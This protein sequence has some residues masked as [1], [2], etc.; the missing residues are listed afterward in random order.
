MILKHLIKP[1]LVSTMTCFVALATAA[2]KPTESPLANWPDVQYDNSIPDIQDVLGYSVGQRITSHDDMLRF[3]NS[4]QKAAPKHIKIFEY[5]ET[6][7]G[8]KLIFAAIGSEQNIANLA[9]F[10]DGMQALSD[11]RVTNKDKAQNLMNDLPASV[12]LEYSVHG[13]EISSTDAAMMTAYHLL[14]GKDDATVKNVMQ[15]S[16]V[17]IDPLQNPDGRSRF[18]ANYYSTVGM[19]HSGDRLT[20]EHNEPWPRGRANHYLFDMN[21]DWLAITQP[22]TKGRIASMNHYRPL[23]VIDLH[24]M[25]GDESY[26]F[27]PSAQ[28]I[29][30]HM[31]QAQI[32]NIN[33]VGRNNA[34]HFDANGFDY[35]T[36]DIFDAFYPGYGDSWPTFYGAAAS[37]YEVA[38]SRG[39]IFRRLDGKN[40]R[41]EDTVL[42]HFVASMSTAETVANNRT[43]LL[44]D[45]YQYQ[46]DAID[47]GKSDKKERVFILP[48]KRDRA[49][50]F[51]LAKLMTEHGVNVYQTTDKV[52]L[53][54]ETYAPGSYYI[55]TAQPRG[56]FVKTTFTEQVDMSKAFI[57]EQ[58]RRR[59]RKL[60]DQIYDVTGWSLPLMY[61]LD[62]DTCGKGV[63]GDHRLV[64]MSDTLEGKVTNPN[65]SV[66]Y[67]VPWGDMAT[68]RFLTAALRQGMAI[69]TAD[70]AFTLD[71]KKRY[72]AGSLIIEVATN[73]DDIATKVQDLAT[74]SGAL[75]DGVNTSWVTD[76]PSFGSNDTY[77]M[78]APKIAMA[79]DE[80]TSSL[81][82]GST[83][84]VIEQQFGYPVNA[85]RTATLANADLRHYQVLILPAGRYQNG[86]G[87]AGADNIKRWV[88]SGGV[89]ITLGSATRFAA[90]ADIGLL[91][92][93]R[94]LAITD[95]S[96]VKVPDSEDKVSTVE[97]KA[98]SKHADLV[99]DSENLKE[100]PDF[101]AGILANVEVDQEH[102]LTAGVPSDVVGLVYGDDI[103]TPIRL[104]SG[105]NLAWFKEE[106]EVLASGYL[107]Q[108]NKKQLAYKP[109]LIHQPSGNGMVIAFTQEP[110][111]RA[112]LDGLNVMLLN[113]IF[114]APAH[115]HVAK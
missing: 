1:L 5:G 85:I 99:K 80:P 103:F 113:A 91:D 87:K 2:D 93:K 109:F 114:S 104:A 49:G 64:T 92:V 6:W 59:D 56:R 20:A 86:L 69:K 8:R 84:F 3:F 14:A 96:S 41:Y 43:K 44:K 55:D 68:G 34:K 111:T 19:E 48:N 51:K 66:A 21:R 95:K 90:D 115:A 73:D 47:A 83:R 75:V 13:N 7:E 40:L 42:R 38:S 52:K 72:P 58:E 94:E 9:E 61:N 65:A 46:V 35:F 107:W 110:T 79:W 36:R 71:D 98:Y 97:G 24:E 23:V 28:P 4:L 76:G 57:K 100:I 27:A 17:F 12:W 33:L 60:G 78:S 10:S 88:E 22:E 62:V 63:S 108:E 81:S 37:T 74:L 77:L 29:N 102:W 39:E 89:L 54:G 53:C 106:K 16:I 31:T 11:P 101:V 70:R 26:Y 112:Y 45:Y 32:A 82:A 18:I 25:G 30:P 50:N 105:K 15:N 67:I